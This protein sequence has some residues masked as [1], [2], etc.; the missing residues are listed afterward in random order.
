MSRPK[1]ELEGDTVSE[2]VIENDSYYFMRLNLMHELGSGE[3]SVPWLKS[4]QQTRYLSIVHQIDHQIR[5]S[6]PKR[7]ILLP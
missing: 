5:S 3:Y 1:G 7:V 4:P 6:F 2:H